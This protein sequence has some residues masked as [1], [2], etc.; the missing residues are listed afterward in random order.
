MAASILNVWSVAGYAFLVL[1][2]AAAL[3]ALLKK[4]RALWWMG[5]FWLGFIP[6]A[7]LVTF[8]IRM[9]DRYLQIPLIGYAAGAGLGIAALLGRLRTPLQRMAVAISLML[10]FTSFASL[11]LAR[12]R[13]WRNPIRLWESALERPPVHNRSYLNY[14]N[15]LVEWG[16]VR[17]AIPYYERALAGDPDFIF[18]Q[19]SFGLACAEV[20]DLGRARALLERAAAF[21][22]ERPH[23]RR[24][25]AS[26][27]GL[28]LL[29][30]DRPEEAL[31]RFQMALLFDQ[32]DALTH[33]QLARTLRVLGRPEEAR[34]RLARAIALEP[35][36]SAAEITLA[37][38]DG[39]AGRV[40]EARARLDRVIAAGGEDLADALYER[41]R[42]AQALGE[43]EQA[44]ADLE[45]ALRESP[46][47]LKKR[48][49]MAAREALKRSE[50]PSF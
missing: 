37:G 34:A 14:A 18:T 16:S 36:N 25:A 15:A 5:M 22:G 43:F 9:A 31:K 29:E 21:K 42:L 41:S 32:K 45:R 13:V 6:V 17:E 49:L 7:Q 28:I 20:G 1:G 33:V 40:E 3:W 2:G 26:T 19:V 35:E 38:L 23:L 4:R 8:W 10:I 11:T 12:Q 30:M 50:K 47:G 24:R 39:D 44:R 27:L 48:R 46:P